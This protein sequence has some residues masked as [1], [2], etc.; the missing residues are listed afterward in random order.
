[1]TSL[2][3]WLSRAIHSDWR[4]CLDRP[5]NKINRDTRPAPLARSNLIED[6][7]SALQMIAL[8]TYLG[9]NLCGWVG[10]L[11]KVAH[12]KQSIVPVFAA[13]RS[14][15]QSCLEW[16]SSRRP[17]FVHIPQISLY[18]GN[19]TYR[20]QVNDPGPYRCFTASA[21]RTGR[22]KLHLASLNVDDSFNLHDQPLS[23]DSA[24][25]AIKS[26]HSRRIPWLRTQRMTV[27]RRS[28]SPGRSNGSQSFQTQP[29][30]R[31]S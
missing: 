2:Q 31:A 3:D 10:R 12:L 5:C 9:Q 15:H 14:L 26:I 24:R 16:D 27:L 1:M 19:D 6:A 8:I 17:I 21:V 23:L 22:R 30:T 25:T 7:F 13:H 29:Q 4:S 18:S 20:T 11:Y 28:H